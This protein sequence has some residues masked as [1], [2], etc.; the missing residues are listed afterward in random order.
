MKAAFFTVAFLAGSA[1]AAP[2]ACPKPGSQTENKADEQAAQPPKSEYEQI[3][4]YCNNNESKKDCELA[5]RRCTGQVPATATMQQF[6]QCIDRNQLCAAEGYHMTEC[7]D[8][9]ETCQKD[10]K[11]QLALG[12]LTALKDCETKLSKGETCA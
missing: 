12:N 3:K 7:T 10:A 5:F 2:S 8:R 11:C 1:L 9:A 4:D 6:F